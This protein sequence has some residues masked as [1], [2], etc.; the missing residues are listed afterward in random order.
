MIGISALCYTFAIVDVRCTFSHSMTGRFEV[1]SVGSSIV[2]RIRE[3]PERHQLRA[4]TREGGRGF[5]AGLAMYERNSLACEGRTF[6][7]LASPPLLSHLG[8][9]RDKWMIFAHSIEFIVDRTS[10]DG[11]LMQDIDLVIIPPPAKFPKRRHT[12]V[13]SVFKATHIP[14]LFSFLL[15]GFRNTMQDNIKMCRRGRTAFQNFDFLLAGAVH[16]N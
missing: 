13:L 11:G 9:Y 14:P 2:M 5:S 6:C 12:Y 10:V 1:M 8:R 3:I 15:T 7:D 4:G 16:H